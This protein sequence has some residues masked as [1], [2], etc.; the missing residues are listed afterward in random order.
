MPTAPTKTRA[1]Q[2][3]AARDAVVVFEPHTAAE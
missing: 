1:M 2:L 3:D